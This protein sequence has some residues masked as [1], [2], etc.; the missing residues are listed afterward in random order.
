MV[1]ENGSSSSVVGA[2]I[3][4][5]RGE[6]WK[7]TVVDE[8]LC[9]LSSATA[10]WSRPRRA[11]SLTVVLSP[12]SPSFPLSLSLTLIHS[13]L[14]IRRRRY[15]FT[16]NRTLS[17]SL[18]LSLSLVRFGHTLFASL[19]T[20][21]PSQPC[22]PPFHWHPE[23][24]LICCQCVSQQIQRREPWCP[25][26]WLLTRISYCRYSFFLP[27]PLSSFFHS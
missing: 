22:P 19:W 16:L 27:F 12:R 17:L 9:S 25:L 2:D 11:V 3:S 21:F 7:E 13:T 26:F 8:Q 5:T 14:G 23:P 6:H 4:H 20:A 24:I 18:S 15:V 1:N 10:A